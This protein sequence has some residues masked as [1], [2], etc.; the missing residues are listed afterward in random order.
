MIKLISNWWGKQPKWNSYEISLSHLNY[1]DKLEKYAELVSW[2]YDRIENPNR[3][4]QWMFS[5]NKICVKFRYEK[6]YLMFI[7][8]WGDNGY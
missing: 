3:H 5:T 6:D 2:I 1:P 7:L 8:V 4:A